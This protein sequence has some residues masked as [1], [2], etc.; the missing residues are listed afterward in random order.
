MHVSR[1]DKTAATSKQRLAI[2]AEAGLDRAFAALLR[3]KSGPLG[4]WVIKKSP[5]Y[6]GVMSFFYISLTG[7]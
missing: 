3:V 6:C 2:E 7:L 1:T 4:A 5:M